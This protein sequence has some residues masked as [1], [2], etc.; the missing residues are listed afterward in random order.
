VRAR[1]ESTAREAGRRQ[2]VSIFLDADHRLQT[3][4]GGLAPGY[5]STLSDWVLQQPG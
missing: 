3:R 4:S 2:E 1:Y 5:L